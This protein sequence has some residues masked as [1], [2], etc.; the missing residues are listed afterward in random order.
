MPQSK[1]ESDHRSSSPPRL[2]TVRRHREVIAAS[3]LRMRADPSADLPIAELAQKAGMSKFHFLRIFEELTSVSPARFL[4]S[5]RLEQ[6]KRLL[7]ETSLPVTTVSLEVG[8]NS[9]ST[10]TRLFTEFVSA[11][12]TLFRARYIELARLSLPHLAK[13]RPLSR[14]SEEFPRCRVVVHTPASFKGP[15]F[16]GI[17]PSGMPRQRPITGAFLEHSGEAELPMN[18]SLGKGFLLAAAFGH[19]TCMKNYFL[20]SSDSTLV[21]AL[22]LATAVPNEELHVNLR[23]PDVFDP[24]IVIALPLLLLGS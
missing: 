7:I 23:R 4:A 14:S 5:L 24:P 2:A 9:L 22:E 20:P 6:A 13:E 3:I 19:D 18:P 12:P 10:F 8:Y 11:S 15:I 17:F 21:A 1:V 16:L